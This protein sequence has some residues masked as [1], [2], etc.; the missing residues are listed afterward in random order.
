MQGGIYDTKHIAVGLHRRHGESLFPS[1]S[2]GELYQRLQQ[3]DSALAHVKLLSDGNAVADQQCAPAHAPAVRP[4]CR[5]AV[6]L[7][8]LHT[9]QS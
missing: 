4:V 8:A 9:V 3:H 7:N 1:T 5:A 6:Q 2:L